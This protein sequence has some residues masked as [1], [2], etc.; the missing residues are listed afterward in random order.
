MGRSK[1]KRKDYA[2]LELKDV[3][4]CPNMKVNIMAV[5]IETGLPK[6]TNGTDQCCN[7]RVIDETQYQTSMS[8][9][10]FSETAQSLPRV[11]P[12]DIILLRHVTVCFSSS[13]SAFP[14][15][16]HYYM[17]F[18]SLSLS[19]LQVRK[20]DKEVNAVFY[21]DASTFALYKGKDAALYDFD[22]YQLFSTLTLRDQ[23]M[24]HIVKLR[25]WLANFQI[26]QGI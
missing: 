12:G 7:I 10:F 20:H 17:F 25:R 23:D 6:F 24:S 22:P 1:R 5:V 8:V 2:L 13:Y 15:L 19:I 18:L 11:T 9:I 4:T 3:H 16:Q 26:H 21:K 14:F